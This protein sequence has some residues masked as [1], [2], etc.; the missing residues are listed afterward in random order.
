MRKH[1]LLTLALL[2][3]ATNGSAAS[4]DGAKLAVQGGI[5][6]RQVPINI[7]C[8]GTADA[9]KITVENTTTGEVYPATLRNG[10]LCFVAENLEA[11]EGALC[12]VRLSD[13]AGEARVSIQKQAGAEALDVRIDGKL[14][15]AYH[16]TND[17]KKPFLWPV[18]GEGD[19][20]LTR[21]FPMADIAQKD[22]RDHP[23]HK[24][25]WTA[26]GDVNGV[27]L[28]EVLSNWGACP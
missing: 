14:F 11:K 26:Y 2:L 6:G 15:T 8:E 5:D 17:N 27:D 16:Y 9:A 19:V 28:A 4:L 13:A 1:V 18:N 24:S 12:A 21:D 22:A 20:G 3:V 10:E 25:L 23:H 7:A